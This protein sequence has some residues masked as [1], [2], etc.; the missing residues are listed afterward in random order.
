MP[1][2]LND[3][4]LQQFMHTFYGYGDYDAPFWFVGMEEGGSRN[5]ADVNHRLRLWQER[6]KRE[7][8]D[9]AEWHLAE[10]PHRHFTG[11]P[12]LQRTWKQLMRILLTAKGQ[13]TDLDALRSYQK[14]QLGRVGGESC[15]VELFPLPSPS[16]GHWL[17]GDHSA[18]PELR[19]RKRYRQALAPERIRHLHAR[20][21]VHRPRA[22][23]FYSTNARYRR[24]WQQVARADFEQAGEEPLY[25]A[26]DGT[27]QFIICKH[28][29]AFGVSNE[30]FQ[31][32]GR[33]V[34]S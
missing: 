18:L 15:L 17:Y 1:E 5:A 24:W 31:R 3:D 22:V 29:V 12:P 33:M 9:L 34:R 11:R 28:P 10:G 2:P 32:I 23:I 27:T 25:R 13:P 19:S 21:L 7:L 6:G 20:I 14:N 4:L 26:R 30:Y 8:E 16:T